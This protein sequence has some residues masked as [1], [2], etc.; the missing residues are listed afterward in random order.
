M[1]KK[2]EDRLEKKERVWGEKDR[3]S[4]WTCRA[5]VAEKTKKNPEKKVKRIKKEQG[6]GDGKGFRSL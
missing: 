3:K 6:F 5:P 2:T 4:A 1:Q